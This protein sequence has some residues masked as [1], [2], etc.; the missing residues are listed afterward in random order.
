MDQLALLIR[1]IVT[2]KNVGTRKEVNIDSTEQMGELAFVPSV[3]HIVPV[4]TVSR[5]SLANATAGH[6]PQLI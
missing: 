6:I 3:R 1:E 2:F 5:S 4:I